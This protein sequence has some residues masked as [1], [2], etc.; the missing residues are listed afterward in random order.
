MGALVLLVL[1]ILFVAGWVW[2]FVELF[3]ILTRR[4]RGPKPSAGKAGQVFCPLCRDG[5]AVARLRAG[6]GPGSG[7]GWACHRCGCEFFLRDRL[8]NEAAA[9]L[10]DRAAGP[11]PPDTRIRSVGGT[12]E[13]GHA[14]A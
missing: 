9:D 3:H 7:G 14:G 11:A 2:V 13:A 12:R 4:P 8:P 6:A 5:G 1:A 10:D